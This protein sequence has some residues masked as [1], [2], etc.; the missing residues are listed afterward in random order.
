MVSK[1]YNYVKINCKGGNYMRKT[2]LDNIR[3]IT[4]VTV[5]IYHVIYMYNSIETAGVI[6]PFK[7]VQYQDMFQYIVYPWFMLLLFVVSG[8]S[9]RYYLKN[10]SHKEF[11]RVRNRKLLV[12]ST[13]GLFVI[14]WVLGYFNML[15]AGAFESMSSVPGVIKFFI[16]VISGT[17]PL[18]Y[19]Q[20]LWVYS[21]ILVLFRL[22]EKDRLSKICKKMPVP[23]LIGMV[24]LIWGSAQIL[25]TPLIVV[26]RFGIYGMGF[27]LGYLFFSHD[28][29]M[30]RVGK[31]W[32]PLT[33]MAVVSGV[34]FTILY[35]GQPYAEH[36]VLDTLLC[37]VYAWF[38]TLGILAFM[39][40]W[41][42]FENRFSKWM[43]KKSWGLYLFH[44]LP[45]VAVACA[46][47]KF[48]PGMPAV[49]CYV[50]VGIASFAGGILIYEVLSR[51]PVIRWLTC[52]IKKEKRK[53]L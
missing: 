11:I 20:L 46:I 22:I 8:M 25:N 21:L 51:I 31:W 47:D 33:V 53:A 9:A 45:L 10:H 15:V 35:W 42:N 52:G 4:V 43:I 27:F 12:P 23:A 17:G 41:G 2:Y 40:K 38:A 37:N 39:Y 34:G 30:E 18:W 32:I 48:I 26:Y 49:L 14:G 36:S 50:L 28:E 29:V 5:V 6:G 16:M 3:W 44:Y 19:I 24:I 13:L 7:S 1:A